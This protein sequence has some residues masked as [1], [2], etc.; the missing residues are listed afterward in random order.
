[1]ARV[2]STLIFDD[3][4]LLREGLKQIL[5]ATR[6]RVVLDGAVS[7]PVPAQSQANSRE[8]LL[9]LGAGDDALGSSDIVRHLSQEYPQMRIVLLG[10]RS[11][12]DQV[13]SA[14][15]SGA[16]G[17]LV[18]TMSSKVLIASLNLI[19]LGER[20][21]PNEFLKNVCNDPMPEAAAV[22]AVAVQNCIPQASE[23]PVFEKSAFNDL[24][25]RQLSGRE[26]TVLSCLVDG[27][28]NKSIARKIDIAEA[29]VKVHVK[30]ILRKIRVKN[31]TQAAMWAA[32]NDWTSKSKTVN[33]AAAA[34]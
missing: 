17:F 26:E 5:S 11:D 29:T 12:D 1:M 8:T 28:T 9:L 31:R 13:A 30:A 20:I 15:R 34:A 32:S 6:F 24:A 2:V 22:Q 25:H 23:G 14:M 27:D 7:E 18:T 33:A 4:T 3:C 21:V 10:G 19:M 16:D